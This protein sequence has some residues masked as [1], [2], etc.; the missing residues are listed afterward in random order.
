[1]QK[2]YSV[3]GTVYHNHSC[4]VFDEFDYYIGSDRQKALNVAL[5]KWERL[6][7]FDKKRNIVELRVCSV[8]D[9]VDLRDYDAVVDAVFD[10]Y[11]YDIIAEFAFYGGFYD[12]V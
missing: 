8:P 1:M 7:S 12:D 9:S 6:S 4:D 11:R 3:I 5:S 10:C 2:V